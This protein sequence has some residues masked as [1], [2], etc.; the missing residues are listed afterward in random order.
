[1]ELEVVL[2]TFAALLAEVADPHHGAISSP[3]VWCTDSVARECVR[4]CQAINL[5]WHL[6]IF[7]STNGAG[8]RAKG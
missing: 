7:Q 5:R 4:F 6:D 2:T 8:C 1:M 3:C